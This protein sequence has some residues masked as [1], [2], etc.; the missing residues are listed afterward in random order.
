MKKVGLTIQKSLDRL[1]ARWREL[2][3]SRQR[4]YTL[5]LFVGYV[6]ITLIVVVKIIFDTGKPKQ[7]MVIEHI[8]NPIPKETKSPL[9]QRDSLS[10]MLKNQ[11]YER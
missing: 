3:V 5:F 10:I 4:R 11:L 7:E 8:V 1:D 9:L 2:S 6:T